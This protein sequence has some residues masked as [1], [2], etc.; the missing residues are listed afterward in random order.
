MPMTINQLVAEAE[1]LPDIDEFEGLSVK[2]IA[3]A[4]VLA[5]AGSE[6]ETRAIAALRARAPGI[7]HNKPPLTEALDDELAPFRAKAVE[8]VGLASTAVIIDQASAAKAH[9][10]SQIM[11]D[12]EERLEGL[13]EQRGR[14]YLAATRHIN[15][16]F[17]A[18][19]QPVALARAGADGKTGGL[20]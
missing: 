14:P 11:R 3:N 9:D 7:G 12:F 10:L 5:P 13:R 6:D 18:V 16:T 15:A 17:A 19:K 4:I 8:L 1:A 2:D 20:R